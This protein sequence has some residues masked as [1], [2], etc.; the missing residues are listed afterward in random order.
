MFWSVASPKGGMGVSVL[1]ATLASHL[2]TGRAV[3]VVDFGGDLAEIFGIAPA[4]DSAPGI[5]EWLVADDSV[6]I[7]ALRN[8]ELEV[9]PSLHLIPAGDFSGG[10]DV[11]ADR[12]ADLVAGLRSSGL[13]LAD[14]GVI[15]SDPFSPRAIVAAASD[16]TTLVVRACY[17][18]LRRAGRLP[19]VFDDVVEIVEGGRALS[20]LD[21]ESVLGQEV[22]SRLAF[23]PAIARAVDGGIIGHRVP[24]RL[25]RVAR[26]LEMSLE[27]FA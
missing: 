18:A 5:A 23:D 16:R 26:E 8:I 11:P 19:L 7:Q 6:G 17:L 2:S 22:T 12:C 15:G 24:R 13:V 21:I 27:V 9:T 4:T 20:T 25:R 10:T 3:T 1:T 14:L